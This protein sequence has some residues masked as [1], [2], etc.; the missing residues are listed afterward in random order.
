MASV[1]V[2]SIV[3]LRASLERNDGGRNASYDEVVRFY[4]GGDLETAQKQGFFSGIASAITSI[5]TPR[6]SDDDTE[7]LT[8][9]N[10]I[11]PAI[12]NK[13]A[14]LSMLPSVNVIT[15]PDSMAP[16]SNPALATPGPSGPTG[17]E[18]AQM[19]GALGAPPTPP[20]ETPPELT[21]MEGMP[22]GMPGMEQELPN[23]PAGTPAVPSEMPEDDWAMSFADREE[24]L[25]YSLL[26]AS[27]MTRRCRDVA[28]SISA[29]GGAVIGVW[30][31]LRHGRPRIFT[32]T[33]QNF[34][35]IAY[36]D[37]GLE[38]QI[39][40]WVDKMTGLEVLAQY[41]IAD[42]KDSDEVE[43]IFYMDEEQFCTVLNKEQYA[44]DPIENVMGVVPIVCV[45][46][47]GVP[48]MIFGSTEM[49]DAIPV[50]K[51]INYHM[52]LIDKMS[53]AMVEPTIFIT[54][55]LE[56][57]DN[58][59]IG[60]GGVATAGKDGSVELLG[61]I[62]LPQGFWTLG[63]VLNNWF[64][65]IADNP[66]AL[67]SQGG[68][69][70]SGKG[71]NAQLGPVAARLQTKLDLVMA[72]WKR[73]I[74]YMLLMWST[75]EGANEPQKATGLQSKEFYYFEAKPTDFVLNGEMW[76][77][78][79]CTV[80]AQA[81]IDKQTDRIG[82][83]QLYQTE[84][85]DWETVANELPEIKDRAKVRRNIDK[86]RQWKAQGMAL[87][88][89]MAQSPAT[90]NV[91][92]G[93]AEK[94]G[95]AME[96]GMLTETPPGPVPTADMGAAPAEP[97]AI[98]QEG[99]EVA[100]PHQRLLDIIE[101]FFN[102]IEKLRGAAWWGGDPLLRPETLASENYTITVWITDSQDQGTITR[103]AA[104]VPA[105]YGHI[106]FIQGQPGEGVQAQQFSQGSEEPEVPLEPTGESPELDRMLAGEI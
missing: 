78:L 50:A 46:T 16:M 80:N 39:A 43:V 93:D 9:I 85:L 34:Y 59:A 27:N 88:A 26:D 76:T 99:M 57:P 49:Q 82:M 89:Q 106:K 30:P 97:E 1:S 4:T 13:V 101:E 45:G 65:L 67:R 83:M 72:A 10:I 87:A 75:F 23:S 60:K 33:P 63:E 86:D 18:T 66:A 92:P 103:A 79:E 74:K 22:G 73:V 91:N 53:D 19:G 21:G 37:D 68:G 105:I 36:D 48:G 90:A 52:A 81:Y 54:D 71:F 17:L 29:M 28:W 32:R 58:L 7:L 55:P 47:L 20:A 100:A 2:D 96:R 15:P 38:L 8:P 77:E 70:Q 98:P 31:D 61:P 84:L 25:I 44:H 64:D 6:S 3:E 94:V 42:Y 95:Y 14:Y 62:Q 56:V 40:L 11:K 69:I 51:Q 12:D 102:G 35:P 5:F 104:K 41:G 24:K